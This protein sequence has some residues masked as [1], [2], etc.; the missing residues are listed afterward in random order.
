M[1]RYCRGHGIV[2]GTVFGGAVCRGTR[3]SGDWYWSIG[4]L[5][6]FNIFT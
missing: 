5:Q 3:Y 4:V 1:A 6:Y 2:G